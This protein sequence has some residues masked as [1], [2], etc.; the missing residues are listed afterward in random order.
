MNAQLDTNEKTINKKVKAQIK[1]LLLPG[2]KITKLLK[3]H[4]PGIGYV[5]YYKNEFGGTLVNACKHKGQITL[6]YNR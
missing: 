4:V 3:K 2:Q 6:R 5:F 1:A